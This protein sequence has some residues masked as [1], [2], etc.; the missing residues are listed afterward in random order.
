MAHQLPEKPSKRIRNQTDSQRDYGCPCGKTYLSYPALFTHIKYKHDGKVPYFFI[1][2]PGKLVKPTPEKARGRP[3]IY[4]DVIIFLC[5][6][7][8]DGLSDDSFNLQ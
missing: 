2:A 4:N 5:Q 7:P 1:K 3:K 8:Q 6:A